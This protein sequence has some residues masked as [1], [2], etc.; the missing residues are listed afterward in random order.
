MS[1]KDAS[2]KVE[3][4]TVSP[5]L[6]EDTKHVAA[7]ADTTDPSVVVDVVQELSFDGGK[8]WRESCRMTGCQASPPLDDPK[9]PLQLPGF[10]TSYSGAKGVL[11]RTR[12]LCD[13]KAVSGK[14]EAV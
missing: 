13:G 6:P 12:V 2:D 10:T 9:G 11:A 5:D 1:E 8:T 3:T 14:A 4:S 7:Y